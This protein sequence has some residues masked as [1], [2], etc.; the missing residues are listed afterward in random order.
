M[1]GIWVTEDL[2]WEDREAKKN[3][4]EVMKEA[5]EN[6]KKRRFSGGKLYIDGALYRKT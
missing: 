2:I 4:K 1:D 3:L 6:G 5:F